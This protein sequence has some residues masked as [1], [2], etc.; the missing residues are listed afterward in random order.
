MPRVIQDSDEELDDDLEID[1]AQPEKKDASPKHSTSDAS[2]TG[3][4]E[5]RR[6]DVVS[7]TNSGQK[8]CEDR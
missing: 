3:K 1:A 5:E 2:S 7:L 6:A 8:L 4:K